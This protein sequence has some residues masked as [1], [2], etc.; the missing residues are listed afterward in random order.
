MSITEKNAEVETSNANKERDSRG[1]T[2][3]IVSL[4]VGDAVCFFIFAAIGRGSHGETTGLAAIPQITMTALPFLTGWF[5]VAPFVGAFRRD[6]M[7]NPRKMASRTLLSWV[8]AWPVSMAI[9][10]IFVDHGIP[11]LTFAL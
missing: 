9:R 4:A 6:V 11:P 3:R 2:L 10:G 8:L 7:A 1:N 5:L